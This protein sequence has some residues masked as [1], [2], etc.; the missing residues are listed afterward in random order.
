MPT[1]DVHILGIEHDYPRWYQGD[2]STADITLKFRHCAVGNDIASINEFMNHITKAV[3]ENDGK[4]T[5]AVQNKEQNNDNSNKGSTTG[6]QALSD[7]QWTIM[8]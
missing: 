8:D 6:E 3:A 5:I 2:I 4:I 7:M 1:I